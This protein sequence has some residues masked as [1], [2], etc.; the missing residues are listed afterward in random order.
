MRTDVLL[1][2]NSLTGDG[3]KELSTQVRFRLTYGLDSDLFLVYSN[4]DQELVTGRTQQ[5]HAL[6]MKLTYRLYP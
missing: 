6:Q 1:Q 3:G 4:Q 5:N 2:W